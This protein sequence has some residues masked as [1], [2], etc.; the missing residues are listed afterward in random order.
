LRGGNAIAIAN[1]GFR[2]SALLFKRSLIGFE[3]DGIERVLFDSG[4]K[5]G[6][7]A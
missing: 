6:I 1:G 4:V 2:C 3:F 5:G 7:C